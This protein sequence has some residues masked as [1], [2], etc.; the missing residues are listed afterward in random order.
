MN[1]EY[2]WAYY[3]RGL[4]YVATNQIDA[5]IA[6]LVKVVELD[7]QNEDA[8]QILRELGVPGY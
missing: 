2:A 5:G 7:P 6:D 3:L 1:L 8:K 4:L